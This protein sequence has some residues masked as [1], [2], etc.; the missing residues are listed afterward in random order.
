MGCIPFLSPGTGGATAAPW[1]SLAWAHN[2]IA[3]SN[4]SRGGTLPS[5]DDDVMSSSS[6]A[7]VLEGARNCGSPKMQELLQDRRWGSTCTRL[8]FSL[9]TRRLRSHPQQQQV[10]SAKLEPPATLFNHS[11]P[12]TKCE[13]EASIISF[14]LFL[15][16]LMQWYII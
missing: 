6:S 13:L 11:F 4:Y 10:P 8:T 12:R 3:A 7:P 5:P 9:T 16:S 1:P 15:A 2:D 14:S